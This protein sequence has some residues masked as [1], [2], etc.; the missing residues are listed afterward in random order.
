V[1]AQEREVGVGD[2]VDQVVDQIAF[3]RAQFVVFAPSAAQSYQN[4]ALHS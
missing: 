2:R 3:L 1:Y 4:T